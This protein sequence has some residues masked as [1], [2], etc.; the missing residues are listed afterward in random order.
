MANVRHLAAEA[1][2][3]VQNLREHSIKT[4]F[5]ERAMIATLEH[6]NSA[7]E[8]KSSDQ[9]SS[10]EFRAE[11]AHLCKML[12]DAN[13]LRIIFFLL[14]EEELNVTE[15]CN[16]LDQSQPAVS[17]HLALLKQAGILKVRRDGKH[18]FYSVCRNR[19]QGVIVQLFE[20]FL[21][22]SNGEVRISNFLLTHSGTKA[23]DSVAV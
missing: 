12:S 21:E 7:T 11:L 8:S 4:Q 22:P 6:T 15:F 2:T 16:R 13:R 5:M 20:S 23:A 18:N 17:H 19:F 9:D 10:E 1:A 14:K 3:F